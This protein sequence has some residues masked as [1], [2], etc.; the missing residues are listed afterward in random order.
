MD[1]KL[2]VVLII[3]V[4]GVIDDEVVCGLF[5]V[6]VLKLVNIWINEFLN[7]K[8]ERDFKVSGKVVDVDEM[9]WLK[10]KFYFLVVKCK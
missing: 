4:E 9:F 10:L 8:V 2:F 5:R 7:V 3:R 1:L 6:L